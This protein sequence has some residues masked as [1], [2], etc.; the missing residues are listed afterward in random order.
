MG[1]SGC[2]QD[3]RCAQPRRPP[4]RRPPRAGRGG[5]EGPLRPLQV[6]G[7]LAA[8]GDVHEPGLVDV[9]AGRI[10]NGDRYLTAVDPPSELLDQEVRGEGASDTPAQNDD[11]LHHCASVLLLDDDLVVSIAIEDAD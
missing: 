6:G 1:V 10:D 5:R 4:P 8:H 9:L 7:P 11:P 2:P 3:R